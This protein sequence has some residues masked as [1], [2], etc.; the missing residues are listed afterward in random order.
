MVV[1]VVV[2][3]RQHGRQPIQYTYI[4]NANDQ[5]LMYNVNYPHSNF[6]HS[7]K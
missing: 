3:E 6:H 2:N 7:K 1:V 5:L 4:V